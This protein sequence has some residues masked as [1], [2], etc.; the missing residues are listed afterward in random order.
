MLSSFLSNNS[1]SSN[2]SQPT[3]ADSDAVVT[4]TSLEALPKIAEGKVRDLYEVDSK[5][6]LFVASDR[7]SAY[8]VIMDNVSGP[9][10]YTNYFH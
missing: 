5:T 9:E 3:M 10:I 6:L 8:D 1:T 7:I 2:H 4:N